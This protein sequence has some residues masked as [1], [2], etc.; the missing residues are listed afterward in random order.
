MQNEKYERA[1]SDVEAV[2]NSMPK[3]VCVMEKL[4]S[5]SKSCQSIW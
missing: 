5:S 4:L 3:G 1:W 2:L